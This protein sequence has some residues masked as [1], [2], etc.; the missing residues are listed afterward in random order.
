MF[1][2]KFVLFHKR[3]ILFG[4]KQHESVQKTQVSFELNISFI[5]VLFLPLLVKAGCK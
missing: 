1:N 4:L 3:N 5:L 2:K